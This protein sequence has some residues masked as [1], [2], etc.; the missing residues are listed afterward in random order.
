[1]ALNFNVLAQVP[2]IAERFMAGEQAAREEQSR[3]MLLQQRQ[4]EFQQAQQDR[5]LAAQERQR[6]AAQLEADRTRRQTFLTQLRDQMAKGGYR[7]NR[8]SLSSMLDFGIESGEDSLVQLATRG[9]KDL[10]DEEAWQSAFGGGARPPAAAAAPA[11]AA[12]QLGAP[13]TDAEDISR[14][15]ALGRTD[16]RFAVT[17][18]V[19]EYPAEPPAPVANAMVAPPADAER[20]RL[21]ALLNSPNKAIRDEARERLKALNAAT[22]RPFIVDGRLVSPTGQVIYEPPPGPVKPS[23][24]YVPVGQDVFDRVEGKFIEGPSRARGALAPAAG[25][26]EARVKPA[27]PIRVRPGEVVISPETGQPIFTAPPAPARAPAARAAAAPGAPAAGTPAQQ[28]KAEAQQ[29]AQTKLSQDLQT[30]LGYYEELAQ[31]GA[32]SSPG[33]PVLENVIAYARSSGL[34][35]EAERAAGTKAQTLR[36][37]IANARQ[38]ILMHVKNATSATAGQMNSNMELQTWLRSLTDP[39]QSIETVRETLKQMDFVIAGVREQ[40]AREAAAKGGAGAAPAAGG[41][42]GWS[43]VR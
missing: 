25:A 7:L 11:S 27:A 28:A 29:A 1:M 34:G 10:G 15:N 9:L 30:Q 37:N 16:P 3:N 12:P 39:Q 42:G 18:P 14:A 6:K 40:V 21:N 2:S 8:E 35:Q 36:D 13:L 24:R 23:E 19:G 33:R 26:R 22:P 17:T 41:S 5:Q 43:V 32:M 20:Q 38:R 4:M 31:M